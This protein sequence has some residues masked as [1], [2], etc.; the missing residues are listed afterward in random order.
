MSNSAGL[1][2]HS[3][4]ALLH[5]NHLSLITQ[6][7][8]LNINPFRHIQTFHGIGATRIG[9]TLIGATLIGATIKGA[10]K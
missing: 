8:I 1:T 2:T 7:I 6:L 10:T 3:T 9:A 4:F 5:M